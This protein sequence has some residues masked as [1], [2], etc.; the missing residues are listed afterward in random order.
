MREMRL[1]EGSPWPFATSSPSDTY[2][3]WVFISVHDDCT[4]TVFH[5]G[6]VSYHLP[7]CDTPYTH[8]VILGRREALRVWWATPNWVVVAVGKPPVAIKTKVTRRVL[9][10]FQYLLWSLWDTIVTVELSD[11]KQRR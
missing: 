4:I 3:R 8:K 2:V 1:R 10:G 7:N 11:K 6:D 9:R 5:D